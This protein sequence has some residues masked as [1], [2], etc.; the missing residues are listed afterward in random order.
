MG[1]LITLEESEMNKPII[2]RRIGGEYSTIVLPDGTIETMWFGDNGD[3]R[4]VARTFP[5]STRLI[6]SRH[7]AEDEG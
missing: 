4:M 2:N 6:A 5:E 1:P 3:Q 7:I